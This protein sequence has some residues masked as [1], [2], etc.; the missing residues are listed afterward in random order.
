MVSTLALQ[1][2]SSDKSSRVCAI[3][4]ASL[5]AMNWRRLATRYDRR[6]RNY[7]AGRALVAVATA[8]A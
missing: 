3:R 2:P 4:S 5:H 7:L 1:S 8:W 6:A